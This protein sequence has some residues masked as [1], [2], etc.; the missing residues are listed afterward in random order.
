MAK[1]P[2]KID[3]GRLE[4]VVRAVTAPNGE[5]Q[6]R[7]TTTKTIEIPVNYEQIPLSDNCDA[8]PRPPTM[9]GFDVTPDTVRRDIAEY[10]AM[11]EKARKYIEI[12]KIVD[13]E[14]THQINC[15]AAV[16]RIREVLDR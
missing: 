15:G 13:L 11:R 5:A 4:F 14:L 6:I 16:R 7:L 2:D 12:E 1:I 10:D 9:R 8:E 3:I